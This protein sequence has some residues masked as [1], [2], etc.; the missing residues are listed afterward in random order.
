[1]ACVTVLV[2]AWQHGVLDH[3]KVKLYFFDSLEL[4]RSA[5]TLKRQ[6][7]LVP[8]PELPVVLRG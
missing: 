2:V 5:I 3:V 7:N 6:E 1:M 4:F 8:L